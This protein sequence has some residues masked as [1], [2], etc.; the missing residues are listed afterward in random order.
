MFFF[1]LTFRA[2]PFTVSGGLFLSSSLSRELVIAGNFYM[3][4][5][6]PPEFR[7][8]KLPPLLDSRTLQ[9][10][11]Y[12]RSPRAISSGQGT[13]LPGKHT[14]P[15]APRSVDW[16]AKIPSWPMFSNDSLG[17]CTAAAA[18]HMIQCWT[19]NTGHSFTPANAQVIAAY[20]ATGHY[21][22][23][24][25]STDQG[26]VE[27]DVLNF[28]RQQ[29][30]AGHKIV[31]YVSFSPQ[32][33]EHTRQAINIFGGIYI[34]LA[35]P[36]SAQNQEVWDAPPQA[37]FFSRV[38]AFFRRGGPCASNSAILGCGLPAV[39]DDSGKVCHP[40]L[41]LSASADPGI[42][43]ADSAKNL[44]R[45]SGF[46]ECGG[47]TPLCH[48]ISTLGIPADSTSISSAESPV[49]KLPSSGLLP[50]LQLPASILQNDFTPG[51]WGGHAVPVL[52]Y[53]ADTL[54]CVTWG[55]K[56]RMT[57]EFFARYCDESYAPLSLDWLNAQ[58]KTP[59]G[60]DLA[61]LQT[62]LN[63]IQC[64]SRVYA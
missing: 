43:P 7:L 29:G 25:P 63:E 1:Q 50:D 24:N 64:S 49:A 57:W 36:L 22:P 15:P 10:A 48:S 17:D 59:E 38:A 34:G 6:S 16:T 55:A 13:T 3:T 60:L 26:A 47:S 23:G 14:L 45:I 35:L 20:S 42:C 33:F 12:L 51:S 37:T 30:I 27:L 41:A 8:G 58:G 11:D 21:I 56:K 2:A 5:S 54:T 4:K 32:N 39:A 61:A 62:D 53:D 52:A 40:T 46:L 18:A 19:A 44:S 31:A 9:L 28:W